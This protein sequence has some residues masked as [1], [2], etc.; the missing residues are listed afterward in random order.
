MNKGTR[1]KEPPVTSEHL[2]LVKHE[3]KAN[4]KK[5]GY[6][7]LNETPASGANRSARRGH[8]G[9]ERWSPKRRHYW[10]VT[11]ENTMFTTEETGYLEGKETTDGTEGIVS[12]SWLQERVR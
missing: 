2:T 9:S 1:I 4:T 8:K 3:W 10:L 7:N 5:R 11:R 6:L 12:H